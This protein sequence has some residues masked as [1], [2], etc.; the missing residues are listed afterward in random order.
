MNLD[1]FLPYSTIKKSVLHLQDSPFVYI[2]QDEYEFFNPILYSEN[3]TLF[4]I[5]NSK[6][7][8]I[9]HTKTGII[10]FNTGDDRL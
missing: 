9:I 5:A 10:K 7:N 6:K 3:D 1:K 8:G 2:F 4:P